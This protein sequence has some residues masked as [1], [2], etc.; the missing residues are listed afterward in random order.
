MRGKMN[1]ISFD[2][3]ISNSVL[4][5]ALWSVIMWVLIM[6]PPV[7][8]ALFEENTLPVLVVLALK[9]LPLALFLGALFVLVSHVPQRV[10]ALLLR[11]TV[12]NKRLDGTEHTFSV[13]P[14]L[15]WAAGAV[16][17][18]LALGTPVYW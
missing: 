11:V 14:E 9:G 15:L 7:G 16:L 5:L 3:N 1:T 10:F 4:S 17:L 12:G 18:W 6:L 8:L 13:V 2:K